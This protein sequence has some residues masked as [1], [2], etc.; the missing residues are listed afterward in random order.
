LVSAALIH[1]ALDL[2]GI[3][4]QHAIASKNSTAIVRP[5]HGWEFFE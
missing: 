2:A 4:L 5:P 1:Q 3:G